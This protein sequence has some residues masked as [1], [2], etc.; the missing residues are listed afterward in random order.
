MLSKKK[1]GAV[2]GNA[3]LERNCESEEQEVQD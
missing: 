3:E 1:E 2:L